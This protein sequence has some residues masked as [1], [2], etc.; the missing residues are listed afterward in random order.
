MKL[1]GCVNLVRF[2]IKKIE[3]QWQFANSAAISDFPLNLFQ[4]PGGECSIKLY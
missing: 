3:K 1:V 2:S 4:A